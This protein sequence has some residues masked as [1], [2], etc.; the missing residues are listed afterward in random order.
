[1]IG[2]I[3]LLSGIHASEPVINPPGY[4]STKARVE[5]V[6]IQPERVLL[7][8]MIRKDE[9]NP[10]IL[11][12]SHEKGSNSLYTGHPVI[13]RASDGTL[14]RGLEYHND[15]TGDSIIYWLSSTDDGNNWST[16]YGF[17]VDLATY[18]SL[19]YWG[20]DRTFF[21]TF[22]SPAS[23]LS[24]AG[25]VL[26][27]F[28][29]ATDPESWLPYWTDFSDNGWHSMIMSDISADNSQ[30]S[31]NWGL[32]SLVMSF[33]DG[34][35]VINNAPHIY[36]QLDAIGH[37]QLS[38]YPTLGGCQSTAVDIDPVG[39][40]TYAVY[41][42]YYPT[43]DQWRLF[44]RQDYFSDWFLPTDGAEIYFDDTTWHMNHPSIAAYDDTI[45]IV[46]EAYNEDNASDTDIVCWSTFVGDVDSLVYRGVVAGTEDAESAPRITHTDDGYFIC[47]FV[48]NGRLYS[49][50]ACDG[51]ISWT[52]PM[53]ISDPI[54]TI[55][56]EYRCSDLSEDGQRAT[57][58]W[59]NDGIGFTDMECAD[60]DN[61]SICD[62]F[63]N[64]PGDY[65]PDQNDG[66]GDGVGD[67]C[68]ICPGYDDNID[69][70]E[71]GYPDDC[72]NC[73]TIGNEDQLDAD[74]DG[75]GDD[76]DL[77]T[78]IDG[79]GFGDE[80]YAAN[81][82]A[83]DNCVSDYN[84]GQEDFDSDGIGDSCDNCYDVINADQADI[85]DDGI[86]DLCDDCVDS[87]G[88]GYGSP[89]YPMTS[90]AIDNCPGVFNTDQ[91][92]SNSDG[93]GDACDLPCGDANGDGD[94]NIGDAVFVISYVFSGGLP[95]ASMWAADV[96]A[97]GD[98]NVGDAVY[99]INFIFRGGAVPNCL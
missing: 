49:T 26:L 52:E 97:D 75:I 73:P 74:G 32:I 2:G 86:G 54:K 83:D 79:D 85:D 95:P 66:D 20:A 81:E 91:A 98:V 60:I 44:V 50:T 34:D 67:L 1:M 69:T 16:A 41:D 27:E 4:L 35:D 57:Y 77:C 42:R 12:L 93:I 94:V 7:P 10:M 22:V 6:D 43:P 38:W 40:K 64:C 99:L 45:M 47:T 61:D 68:D 15:V 58:Q 14:L 89:G 18:P 28:Q 37:T 13:D 71:D 72:D 87:D 92:D 39:G 36:S 48:K 8:Q 25:V 59:G 96:N 76:C 17:D 29:D 90:C 88:D 11:D 78:D 5:S 9:L 30:Q 84:P 23:F 3:V 55:R 53:L 21:G 46:T 24:G 80:A 33:D 51:G 62:C 65:N 63:D 70:D 56:T 31:W 82:C 19:D